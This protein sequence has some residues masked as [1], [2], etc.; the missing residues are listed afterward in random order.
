MN[1]DGDPVPQQAAAEFSLTISTS[2]H[3]Q[4]PA[5]D[6]SFQFAPHRY[7]HSSQSEA[8]AMLHRRT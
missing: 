6:I 1:A 3:H 7:S 4:E 2:M 8:E 5:A